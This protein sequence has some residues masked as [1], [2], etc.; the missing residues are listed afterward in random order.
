MKLVLDFS[1][2]KLPKLF[3]LL[4]VL[5]CLTVII[6]Q[7]PVSWIGGVLANQSA[8]RVILHQPTGMPP[9]VVAESLYQL[10]NAFIG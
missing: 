10:L 6:R 9:L 4:L 3:W 5:A 7:L 8:C 1:Y 2:P